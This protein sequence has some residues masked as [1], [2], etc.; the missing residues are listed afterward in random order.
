M[1]RGFSM[2]TLLVLAIGLTACTDLK[3]SSDRGEDT[4]DS[5]T[6]ADGGVDGGQPRDPIIVHP[7]S[8]CPALA[9]RERIVVDSEVTGDTTWTCDRI[10]SIRG[11]IYVRAPFVLTI[12]AGTLVLGEQVAGADP[13]G[14]GLVIERGARL[15]ASGTAI[16]PIVF[17]SGANGRTR[18]D[19]AGV[20]LLGAAPINVG[21]QTTFEG[22]DPDDTRHEYGGD[23]VNHDCG[24]V[25]YVRI[26]FAGRRLSADKEIN[27]LS[28]AACGSSTAVD[29]VQVHMGNDDGVE[30]FGGTT[31]IR[32][33]VIT[34]PRDDGLDWDQGWQGRGQFIIIQQDNDATVGERGIE[35]DNLDGMPNAF[36]RSFARLSQLTLVGSNA[37]GGG[38]TG[39]VL[40]RG[41]HAVLQNA[42]VMGFPAEAVDVQSAESV[43]GTTLGD[44][45]IERSIFFANGPGGDAHFDAAETDD[46]DGFSESDFFQSSDKNNRFGEDPSLGDP[47][48]LTSPDFR[49]AGSSPAA[50]AGVSPPRDGFFDVSAQHIGALPA[51]GPAWTDT[52]TAFPED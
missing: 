12:E 37:D 40:R 16:D 27:G 17:T 45:S 23:D 18:G 8:V 38:Q 2:H 11:L 4:A 6:T 10:Y 5:G 3:P 36:P 14:S 28:L 43:A 30:L 26:E 24:T 22:L 20:I 25:R 13:N 48:N 34:R 9:D 51:D 35:A 42:I 52:W 46:D 1:R 44:L 33:V 39:I 15:E 47:F 19:W 29:F 50:G 7:N 31:D 21:E 49:P 32:H 41:T